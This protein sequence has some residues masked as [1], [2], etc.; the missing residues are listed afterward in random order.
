MALIDSA[1]A[2]LGTEVEIHIRKKFFKGTVVKKRF[3]EKNYKK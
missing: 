1:H 3:Y 2:A